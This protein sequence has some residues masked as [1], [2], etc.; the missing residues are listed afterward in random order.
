MKKKYGAKHVK[1]AIAK[2]W[3]ARLDTGVA[4][5]PTSQ[6]KYVHG[7]EPLKKSKIAKHSLNMTNFA[8]VDVA[9]IREGSFRTNGIPF[10]YKWN[11]IERDGRSW[12]GKEFYID[13]IEK[14]NTEYGL[15]D[16]IYTKVL[17]GTNW[18][19]AKVKIPE[20]S[21]TKAFLERIENGLVRYVSSTHQ[22]FVNP[23]N[24]A[25]EV[26]KIRGLGISTVKEPEVEGA[27]ILS[28]QRNLRG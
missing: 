16:K 14:S 12:E 1:M 18:L 26:E 2:C 19:C 24:D 7:Q 8:L 27:R 21:F 5:L 25:R 28:C 11:V 4:Q 6:T 23:S 3:K 9:F 22:F 15:I 10:N 20:T 17:D 13:H